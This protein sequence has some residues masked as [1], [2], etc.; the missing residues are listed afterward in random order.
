MTRLRPAEGQVMSSGSSISSSA[1]SIMCSFGTCSDT[2]PLPARLLP[3]TRRRRQLLVRASAHAAHVALVRVVAP[4]VHSVL[5]R[6][7][8]THSH[9]LPISR[10]V[11]LRLRILH[12]HNPNLPSP[13]LS[14]LPFSPAPLHMPRANRA[15]QAILAF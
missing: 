4:R 9:R 10:A 12:P 1:S 2:R 5:Q 11:V 6:H 14:T 3:V 15:T 8:R 7:S 13:P